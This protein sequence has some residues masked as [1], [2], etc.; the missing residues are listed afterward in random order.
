MRS[1][2]LSLLAAIILVA[3]APV[4]AVEDTYYGTRLK[5]ITKYDTEEY[6]HKIEN[7]AEYSLKQAQENPVWSPDGKTIAMNGYTGI[8]LWTIPAEGGTPTLVYNNWHKKEGYVYQDENFGIG[9]M[10]TLAFTPDGKELTFGDYY[11]DP[12]H[13][14][15]IS[16]NNNGGITVW[17]PVPVIKNVN[18][19][20][21]E[22]RT[23]VDEGVDGNWSPD[24][25]YFVYSWQHTNYTG[26]TPKPFD[27]D[28]Y[29]LEWGVKVLDTQTGEIKTLAMWA[30]SP[31]VTPDSKYVIYSSQ[32]SAT[33]GEFVTYGQNFNL[34]R[35]PITGG[36]PEQLTFFTDTS[37]VKCASQAMVSPNGE[38]VLFGGTYK[39][40]DTNTGIYKSGL[41]V[42]NLKTGEFFKA[43]PRAEITAWN[44]KWSPDGKKFAYM[45]HTYL[46]NGPDQRIYTIDFQPTPFWKPAAVAEE[47]PSTFA[48]TGNYPNPFNPSTTISFTLSSSG[49]ASLSVFNVAGQKV[50]E[51]VNGP[52]SAGAHSVAWDGRD[53]NGKPVS[54][55]V[56]LSRLIMGNQV[57]ASRMLLAK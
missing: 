24:G 1:I 2:F 53:M 38:W 14:S 17:H 18:L 49:T 57:S 45:Q 32:S 51:L 23:I 26:P 39:E 29:K 43:F 5:V 6:D 31:S 41:C 47:T 42:L 10:T 12:A 30:Y 33:D 48:L 55:G 21:G 56:Y 34:Y 46:A 27:P 36:A 52:L 22:V 3:A 16:E 28:K 35:I 11:L 50:R 37:D 7:W 13:G 25:R 20:T 19:V 40:M 15:A 8:G 4:F 44:P 54:S 9:D